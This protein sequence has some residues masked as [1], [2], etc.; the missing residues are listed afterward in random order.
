MTDR[1][2]SDLIY[3]WKDSERVVHGDFHILL[4]TTFYTTVWSISTY[5]FHLLLLFS[6]MSVFR[7]SVVRCTS[8]LH[9]LGDS[10]SR[11]SK[12]LSLRPVIWS[13]YYEFFKYSPFNVPSKLPSP[14]SPDQRSHK[15][16]FGRYFS[17]SQKGVWSC[18]QDQGKDMS[19]S[20]LEGTGKELRVIY[21]RLSLTRRW[22]IVGVSVHVRPLSR[23][24]SCIHRRRKYF[25]PTLLLIC[26]NLLLNY[27]DYC[28]RFLLPSFFLQS[29]TSCVGLRWIGPSFDDF[30]R[31]RGFSVTTVFGL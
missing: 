11:V 31:G 24:C 30:W 19:G 21:L 14:R 15:D 22:D 7:V 4:S 6:F 25:W 13:F 20:W 26:R 28:I 2:S 8:L 9:P 29:H 16:N 1:L 12:S 17:L 3:L 18:E 23:H 27:C 5:H 10:F